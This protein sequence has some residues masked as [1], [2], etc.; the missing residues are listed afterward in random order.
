QFVEISPA[1][2]VNGSFDGDFFMDYPSGLSVFN[3]FQAFCVDPLQ[4]LSYGESVTYEVQDISDLA[5]SL[6][7][8]RLI[9]GYLASE[10]TDLDAAAVQ[11]AIWEVVAEV[12]RSEY[13]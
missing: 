8:A 1:V 2:K 7:I 11:W 6:I 4:S 3:E 9:G 10:R 12:T 13:S 5:S